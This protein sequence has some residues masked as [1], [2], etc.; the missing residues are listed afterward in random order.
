MAM[1][2]EFKISASWLAVTSWL[3][4][5][6]AVTGWLAVASWLARSETPKKEY[7]KGDEP[8]VTENAEEPWFLIHEGPGKK[9]DHRKGEKECFTE[10]TEEPPNVF[11]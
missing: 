7:K 8:H 2:I 10:S 4:A 9:A 11:S 3:A 6:L 5:L 1:N